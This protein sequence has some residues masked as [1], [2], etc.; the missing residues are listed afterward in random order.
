M[1]GRYA[2]LLA[3]AL[4]L[5]G[6]APA[7]ALDDPRV[8]SEAP[9]TSQLQAQLD[10]LSDAYWVNRGYPHVEVRWHLARFTEPGIAGMD[11]G[12]DIWL[13]VVRVREALHQWLLPIVEF[14]RLCTDAV[15]ERGH[16]LEL[17]HDAGGVMAASTPPTPRVCSYWARRFGRA[18][19]W[20]ARGAGR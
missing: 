20:I 9:W 17:D 5:A 3:A 14:R 16:A 1:S 13:D 4:I 8:A 15:H 6:P 19:Q 11:D 2:A 12:P 10:F 18:N 7:A